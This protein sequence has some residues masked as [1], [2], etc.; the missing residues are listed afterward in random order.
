MSFRTSCNSLYKF[1]ETIFKIGSWSTST[2]FVIAK[3][4]ISRDAS[5][6]YF[7][8][9]RGGFWTHP[10]SCKKKFVNQNFRSRSLLVSGA[11]DLSAILPGNF[12]V[13]CRLGC[14]L[15][16]LS[17]WLV[18]IRYLFWHFVSAFWTLIFNF[19]K[20]S[21]RNNFVIAKKLQFKRCI[22]SIFLFWQV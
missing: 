16:F 17:F 14:L 1:L 8:S 15:L 7:C 3:N 9:D 10:H 4:C 20:W 11:L 12:T 19:V 6:W 2:N 22:I 13:R 5:F 21:T 18:Q